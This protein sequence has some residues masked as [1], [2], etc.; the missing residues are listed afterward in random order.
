MTQR[1]LAGARILAQGLVGPSRFAGPTEAARAF[2]AHQGQDLA[3]VM[4]SLALRTGGD[5]EEVL[6]AFDRSRD[7]WSPNAV[8][9]DNTLVGRIEADP[10][11]Q[12]AVGDARRM[13]GWSESLA[14]V[15]P[16]VDDD[17]GANGTRAVIRGTYEAEG[18]TVCVTTVYLLTEHEAGQH[19]A[20]FTVT[21]EAAA[22]DM[23]DAV[24]EMVEG[25][26]VRV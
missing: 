24:D 10:F 25:L 20:Q 3:G 1:H 5:I 9:V 22:V 23:L 26:R 18:K 17:G 15:E 11:M 21:I 8:L 12:C 14:R 19:L 4:A 13:P 16:A 7:G 6:A 2:G